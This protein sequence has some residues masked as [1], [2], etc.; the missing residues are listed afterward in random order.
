MLRGGIGGRYNRGVRIGEKQHLRVDRGKGWIGVGA[1][2][3]I[4]PWESGWDLGTPGMLFN[5]P[6]QLQNIY[7]YA[8]KISV[9][10]HIQWGANQMQ[11][12]T[13]FH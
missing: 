4:L 5:S 2:I 6:N 13:C 1:R 11:H 10:L 3:G 9:A 12:V 7:A 8:K